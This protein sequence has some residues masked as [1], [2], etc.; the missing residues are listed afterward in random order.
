MK[1]DFL[2]EALPKYT[3]SEIDDMDIN[4]GGHY[5]NTET[6]TDEGDSIDVADGGKWTND[7]DSA[8]GSVNIDGDLANKGDLVIGDGDDATDDFH[9]GPNGSVSNDGKLDA[10]DAGHTEIEGDYTTGK[11]GETI[12]GDV[13]VS[14]GGSLTNH[15]KEEGDKLVVE[16]GGRYENTGDSAWDEVV[17]SGDI[18]NTGDTSWGN[19]TI[20]GGTVTVETGT[21]D[22]GDV[23]MT[24]G[25]IVVGN[26]LPLDEANK[27]TAKWESPKTIDL[28][29]FVIG[30]GELALGKDAD[31][32]GAEMGAPVLP[33]TPSRV[34]ITTPIKIGSGTIAVGSDVY[35]DKDHLELTDGS[36]HFGEDSF[37]LISA[38]AA[39]DK[40]AAISTETEGA[41]LTIKDGATLTIGNIQSVGDYVITEGFDLSANLDE[42]G[43]WI[44]GWSQDNL[45]ALP[46]SGSGLGWNL[47]AW[48]D[49]ENDKFWVHAALDDV[50]TLY[51]DIG[52]PGIANDAMNQSKP[53]DMGDQFIQGI[54][55]DKDATAAEKTQA[56]N[57]VLNIA[58]SGA[59]MQTAFADA[60]ETAQTIES[61]VS[62][63]GDHF[64]QSG[65]LKSE[66][67]GSSLWV[68]ATAG[69]GKTHGVEASG[70]MKGG[71]D[72]NK[73]GIV[74]GADYVN[75]AQSAVFGAAFSY[76]KS[77]I[78]STGDWL[79]TTNSVESYGFSAY[80]AWTPNE[81]F[82]LLGQIGYQKSTGTIGQTIGFAGFGSASADVDSDVIFG[83][84]RAEYRLRFGD[85][86]V[87]PHAGV[88]VVHGLS[89]DFSTK[90][91]GR[92]AFTSETESTTT[93]QTPVGVAV[94]GT[95][96]TGGGWTFRPVGDI[97]VAAQFG[98]TKQDVTVR[99][100]RG[101][102]DVVS[103]QFAGD[104]VTNARLGFELEKGHVTIGVNYGFSAGEIDRSHSINANVRFL[105]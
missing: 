2:L 56:I 55:T 42:E 103:G 63:A 86:I 65:T 54:L 4:N 18:T 25:T 16:E 101:A 9:V 71:T 61:R 29:I 70:N 11:D 87:V 51:P 32:F 66:V 52:T 53:T 31:K 12:F 83:G 96:E 84:L 48:W 91:N 60:T 67:N 90:V 88:R 75:Q 82:N 45:Y 15:G 97:S 22:L 47:T 19:V 28:D 1:K 41:T 99:N 34:T 77:S 38:S 73:S 14:D 105:F 13:T 62:F 24:S 5:H 6:G 7:G 33:N 94:R 36:M 80:G 79:D 50:L 8:W 64:D 92:A 26:H 27:A 37:T 102:S 100:C 78:Q 69:V 81:N 3:A 74:L 20:D 98:D 76:T 49:D 43:N 17:I 44:G 40:Q 89:G 93:W 10:S 58:A 72:T 21:T 35:E 46:Q 95:F 68:K 30:N 39:G 59:T 57:S 85:V 104:F 23:T